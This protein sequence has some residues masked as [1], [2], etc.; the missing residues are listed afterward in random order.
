L[1][2][3]M[4]TLSGIGAVVALALLSGTALA[5]GPALNTTT[6]WVNELGSEMTIAIGSNGAITGTYVSA[7]GCGAGTAFPL[8][9]WWNNQA[10]TFT[11]NWGATC[12]SLTAWTGHWTSTGG[13]KIGTLWYLA[14]GGPPQWNSTV[15]G[16]DTFTQQ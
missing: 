4:R 14:V 8:I 12:N 9:G 11:V 13:S 5:Q 15:A 3:I 1:E 10:M 6:T 2:D 7:V 16:T